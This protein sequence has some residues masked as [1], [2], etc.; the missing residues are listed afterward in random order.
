MVDRYYNLTPRGDVELVDRKTVLLH[1]K[2][3]INRLIGPTRDATAIESVFHQGAR[4]A[5]V[6]VFDFGAI[7]T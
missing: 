2:K 7:A 3:E 6:S 5:D 4:T 1:M